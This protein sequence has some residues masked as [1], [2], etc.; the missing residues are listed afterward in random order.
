MHSPLVASWLHRLIL[1][2]RRNFF[3]FLQRS[4]TVCRRALGEKVEQWKEKLLSIKGW[5]ILI[6]YVLTNL[7]LYMLLFFSTYRRVLQRLGYFTSICFWQGE[8]G[9]KRYRL[10]K[11]SAIF[12]PKD[13]W[14]L[15][16]QDLQVKNDVLLTKWLFKLLTEDENCHPIA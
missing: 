4:P 10:T 3:C 7:V 16:I 1:V 5:L 14:G 8:S 11:W 13:Q 12:W 15:G 2:K 6:N 9:K